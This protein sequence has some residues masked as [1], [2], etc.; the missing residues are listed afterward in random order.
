MIS[1]RLALPRRSSPLAKLNVS[2]KRPG[3]L[4]INLNCSKSSVGAGS[5]G[6]AGP[7]A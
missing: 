4:G 3:V 2:A 1:L 5:G 7:S 6:Y